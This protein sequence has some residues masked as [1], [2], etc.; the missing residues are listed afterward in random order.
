MGF[1]L[2]SHTLKL[3][4]REIID[5]CKP[6]DCDHQD[7]NDFFINDV[8]QNEMEGNNNL[9]GSYEKVCTGIFS[10]VLEFVLTLQL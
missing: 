9:I 5:S 3:F 1:I 7:L 4:N 10:P 6:F 8:D 2:D